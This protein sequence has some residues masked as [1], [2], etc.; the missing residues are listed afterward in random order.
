MYFNEKT[1]E[2]EDNEEKSMKC[3]VNNLEINYETFG[4]GKPIIM[5]HGYYP[6]HRLMT[7]C[8]EPIF[9]DRNDYRRIY[10]D[11]PGMGKTKSEAWIKNSDIMLDIVI[12]FIDI[13]VPNENF[14]L[15]GES[16][17]GYLAR[18][19]IYK[20][21]NK[22]DGLVLLCPCIIADAKKRVNPPHI[23]LKKDEYLLKQI[24]PLD[25]E[26]FESMAVVQNEKIWKRYENEILSGVK[27]ADD[28]FLSNLKKTGYEFSFDVD[29]IEEKYEEPTL[30]LL[31]RQDSSVGYKDAW[32]I[33]D[34]YP[35][36]T[37][38]VLDRAGH[39]LQIE[40]EELFNSLVNEWLVRVNES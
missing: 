38:S 17:G 16:Y 34:N 8:F 30:I 15:V 1:K 28:K 18:G 27:I 25:S 31:G 4:E 21:G 9:Q 37:F 14:L 32:S 29:K 26:D 40:Q 5:L 10:I 12:D 13:I 22:V 24:P 6:D 39:N 3:V 36:A 33:L 35:R 20:M 19:I 7:G 2:Y 11:L 23:V